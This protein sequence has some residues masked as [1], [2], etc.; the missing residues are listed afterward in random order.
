MSD[1]SNGSDFIELAADIVSA[2]VSNNSVAASDLPNLIGEIHGA[3]L[4]VSSGV[5]DGHIH[6]VGDSDAHI[7][8]GLV[9]ILIA[10]FSGK[11]A[12]D[13]LA[14][15]ALKL[16]REL[17]L[18]EHLTPQRSNGLKSMVDRMRADAR[19]AMAAA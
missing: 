13:I 19:Q 15:D 6:F 9:A 3:L 18:E 7:V 1:G 2:Y 16:F 11:S 10:L 5:Q 17:D 8:K 14:I 4:R 12:A